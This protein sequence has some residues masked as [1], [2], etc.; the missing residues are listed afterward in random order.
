MTTATETPAR[1]RVIEIRDGHAV[2]NPVG[3]N[4]ELHLVPAGG[5]YTGPVGQRLE[6]VVRA[7]ARKLWT[8]PSGGNFVV[9]IFGPPRIIQGRIRHADERQIIVQAGLPVVIDL[10]TDGDAY[11]LVNGPLTRGAMVNV[12]VLPGATFEPLNHDRAHQPDRPAGG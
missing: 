11:D 5:A 3:T 12:T 10:P 6:G 4:Y 9:P 1:G 7:T 2:F 8:V